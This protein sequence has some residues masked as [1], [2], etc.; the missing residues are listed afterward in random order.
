M[1]IDSL[2]GH[3]VDN[4]TVL[5]FFKETVKPLSFRETVSLMK[6]SHKETRT[7]K[8]VLRA[9]VRSGKLVMTRK[10]LYGPS[11]D[12]SL[13]NGYFE[14]HKGGYGFV[15]TEKPGERDLFVPARATMGAMKARG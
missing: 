3:M 7:L 6:L 10:G 14:A 8:K 4:E 9:M 11:E 2:G 1:F 13:L 15:I 12:M 5:S